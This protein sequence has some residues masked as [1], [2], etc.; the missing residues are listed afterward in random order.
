[1]VR[2]L[3]SRRTSP[4]QSTAPGTAARIAEAIA[5]HQSGNL[6][7]AEELYRRVLAVEPSQADAMHFLGMLEHQ[8]GRCEQALELMNRSIELFP[9][10]ADYL[11]NRGNVLRCLGRLDEAEADYGRV[12]EL[13][14]LHANALNNLGIVSRERGNYEGAI[15]LYRRAIAANPSHA[16]AYLNLGNALEAVN[17]LEQALEAHREA[18]RLRP[19]HGDTYRHMAGMFYALGR[20]AEAAE[21]YRQWLQVEPTHPV[22]THMLAACTETNVPERASEDFVRRSFD[23]FALTFDRTL[24]RLDYRAPVLVGQTVIDWSQAAE[25]RAPDVLDAGCGTGLVGTMLR[26]HVKSLAGVDLSPKMIERAR[27]REIYDELVVDDLITFCASRRGRFD[28]IVSADT[29]VYFGALDSALSAMANAVRAG[30]ALVFT[31]ERCDDP[32][33][34]PGY[35]IHPHGRYSHTERYL[36]A[37]LNQAGAEDIR[38]QPVELRK[39]AGKWVDGW[40]VVAKVPSDET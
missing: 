40:L 27:V 35:R 33:L 13:S 19:G 17:C 36:R 15:E 21:L 32:N 2:R 37:T 38:I 23:D 4:K 24:Q 30:G 6:D 1:M 3:K 10:H 12:L 29:L 18:L 16:D 14:P 34:D 5:L 31:T 22:A 11:S 8:R 28:V 9:E 20:I 25:H 26:P 39:E 7:Q